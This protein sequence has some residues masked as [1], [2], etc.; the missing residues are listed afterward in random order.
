ML[1]KWAAH[2][3]IRKTRLEYLQLAGKVRI[4]REEL[5]VSEKILQALHNLCATAPDLARRSEELSQVLQIDLT[6]IEKVLDNY[7]LEGFAESFVDNEGK[8]RYYL[9]GS[10][11]IKVCALFT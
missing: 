2:A 10:G 9:T 8:K 6:E 4:L 5:P 3:F 1:L 11:I 7:R